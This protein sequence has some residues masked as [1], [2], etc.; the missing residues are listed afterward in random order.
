MVYLAYRRAIRGKLEGMSYTADFLDFIAASPS[1]YHAA[2]EVSRQ[3]RE[4]GFEL[5]LIHI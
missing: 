2:D 3:L 1:S 4:A 5:S